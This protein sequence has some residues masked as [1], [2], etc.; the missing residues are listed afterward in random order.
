MHPHHKDHA[1]AAIARVAGAARLAFGNVD[2]QTDMRT[3]D[4][5]SEVVASVHLVLASR[6]PHVA[7]VDG[8]LVDRPVVDRALRLLHEAGEDA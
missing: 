3:A 1:R 7:V 5:D 2:Y 8:A 4:R 6:A